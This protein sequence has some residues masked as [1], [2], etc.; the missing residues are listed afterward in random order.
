MIKS[1][2]LFEQN[3]KLKKNWIF[4]DNRVMNWSIV[5]SK[6]LLIIYIDSNTTTFPK[7]K[8]IFLYLMRNLILLKLCAN[9][10]D[11]ESITSIVDYDFC[12]FTLVNATRNFTS[13]IKESFIYSVNFYKIFE[14]SYEMS[15]I[16]LKLNIYLN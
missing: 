11:N 3:C 10:N 13:K 9:W 14:P 5:I 7:R 16:Q 12:A 8:V 1:S 15:G 2:H 6:Y 4:P